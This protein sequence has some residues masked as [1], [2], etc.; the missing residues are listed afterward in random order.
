[1]KKDLN[2]IAALE[3]AVKEKYGEIATLNPKMFWDES[4]EKNYLEESKQAIKRE[5]I[6][7][8]S[9][10]KIELEGILISKNALTKTE[11]RTCKYCNTYSFKKQDDLYMNKFSACYKCYL[12]KLEDKKNG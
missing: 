2:Y 4:K 12:C 3:K 5:Y 1:M 9:K 10:E 11:S 8:D 6:V 7:R